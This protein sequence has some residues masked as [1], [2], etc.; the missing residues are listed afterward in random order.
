MDKKERLAILAGFATG[1]L[2]A[3]KQDSNRIDVTHYT[4]ENPNLPEAV[5]GMRIVQISDLH[6]KQFGKEQSRLIR[7]VRAQRPHLIFLTGDIL[8]N[9]DR[10]P[11]PSF[12]LIREVVKIA[13]CYYVPGN[14]EAWM[15]RD[16]YRRWL[17]YLEDMGVHALLND[18]VELTPGLKLYGVED[19]DFYEGLSDADTK[20]FRDDLFGREEE[21][22]A[23]NRRLSEL[24]HYDGVRILL[25]HR[26]ERLDLYEKHGIDL[27]FCGHAHGGQYRLPL[28]GALG[29]PNQGFFPKLVSGMKQK[30]GTTEIISRGLG[31]S[32]IPIRFLCRPEVVTVT[33]RK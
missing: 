11:T 20:R 14:H 16:E 17:A 25:S 21:R 28:I 19:P 32:M 10:D 24:E 6:R 23:L 4:Y 2:L 7:A 30:G 5:D 9:T 1:L 8:D 3:A 22:W 13:E 26:P 27:V 12:E 18:S 29:A 31:V 15:D 33:L